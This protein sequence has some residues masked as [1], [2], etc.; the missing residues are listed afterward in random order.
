MLNSSLDIGHA[1]S[2]YGNAA[3]AKY[4]KSGFWI[5]DL[6]RHSRMKLWFITENERRFLILVSQNK[7]KYL[8]DPNHPNF[9]SIQ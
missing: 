3:C 1:W 5:F 6:V 7:I 4:F 8:L 2:S 9:N